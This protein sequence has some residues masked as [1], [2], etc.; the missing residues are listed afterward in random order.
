MLAL[1]RPHVEPLNDPASWADIPLDRL[2]SASP[3]DYPVPR[4]EIGV[5]KEQ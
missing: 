5:L 2:E 1:T 4:C 3:E